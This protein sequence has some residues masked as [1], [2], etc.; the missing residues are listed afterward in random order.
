[1]KLSPRRRFSYT[2]EDKELA[3]RCFHHSPG[4]Y[5]ELQHHFQLPA[6]LTLRR[7][8][9]RKLG[10]FDVSIQSLP[11]LSEMNRALWFWLRVLNPSIL[12]SYP[13]R[14]TNIFIL[15]PGFLHGVLYLLKGKTAEMTPQEKMCSLVIDEMAIK[16]HLDYN[17][18]TDSIDGLA[19]DGSKARQAMVFMVR[20]IA[21]TWK[22]VV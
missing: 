22:Q 3:L 14:C 9:T 21:G 5:Y 6:P 8:A 13:R 4:C 19:G 2:V 16:G 11:Q 12:T 10:S 18:R 1:M 20:A 7:Y 15:Q 17:R